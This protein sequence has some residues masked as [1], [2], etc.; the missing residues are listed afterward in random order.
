MNSIDTQQAHENLIAAMRKH[1]N[2]GARDSEGW[3]AVECVTEAIE[4]GKPFPLKGENPFQLYQSIPG[5][6]DASIELV[7]AA[8]VYWKAALMQRLGL[9]Q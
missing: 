2:F 6:R 8:Q 5:W 4:R 7:E 9:E 1:T 3:D